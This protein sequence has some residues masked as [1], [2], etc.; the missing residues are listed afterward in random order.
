MVFLIFK[1]YG[2]FFAVGTELCFCHGE[3]MSLVKKAFSSGNF[4]QRLKEVWLLL[5]WRT[6]NLGRQK[7]AFEVGTFPN[8]LNFLVLICVSP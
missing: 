3:R 8:F 6:F 7:S 4:P 1:M 5:P 2:T